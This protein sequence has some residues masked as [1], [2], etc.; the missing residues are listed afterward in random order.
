MSEN[1]F[2]LDVRTEGD[3]KALKILSSFKP[4]L[5]LTQHCWEFPVWC[6]LCLLPSR[7]LLFEVQ[8]DKP[9]LRARENTDF[10][11]CRFILIFFLSFYL[12]T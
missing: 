6:V 9:N 11:S 2:W 3:D 5:D 8:L 4:R 12:L 1:H 10:F 7:R